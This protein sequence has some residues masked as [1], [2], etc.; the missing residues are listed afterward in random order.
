M[1]LTLIS[2]SHSKHNQITKD[3]I[4]GDILIHAGDAMNSGYIEQELISF[5][6]WFDN[7]KG[8]ETK[9]FIAG[10][11]CRLF[12]DNP[13]RALEI[14]NSYDSI[15][16]LQDSEVIIDGVKIYGS[17][18][19]PEFYD[20]AFNLPRNGTG[21]MSKWHSIPEDTD[22]LITH[23]PAWGYLDT[24][25]SGEHLGCE[26]LRN[27]TD[28][29]NPKLH[30]F[31]HIHDSFGYVKTDKT[32]FFNASVLNERYQY[33]NNPVNIEWDKLTNKIKFL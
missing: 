8:Y 23:S 31:G 14:V 27:R 26:Q 13:K 32:H 20:W 24:V 10:N 7:I 33:T 4:G 15:I 21:L 2:D 3:L 30:C 29:V 6:E 19:Q 16:Y 28:V 1:K 9:I 12:E 17:P 5:C 25:N 18:W 11:H 22:I